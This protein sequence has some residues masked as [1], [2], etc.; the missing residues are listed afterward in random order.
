MHYDAIVVG[1]G[2]VGSAE[3]YHLANR[4]ARGDRH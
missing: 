4:G 1:S 3:L 2:G